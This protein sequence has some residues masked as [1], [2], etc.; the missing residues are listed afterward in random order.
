MRINNN[1]LHSRINRLE[2]LMS[3]TTSDVKKLELSRDIRLLKLML[4]YTEGTNYEVDSINLLFPD[5]MYNLNKELM[6][7]FNRNASNIF[8]S[9]YGYS[10]RVRLPLKLTL[11]RRITD[12]VYDKLLI[13]F[14]KEYDKRLLDIYMLLKREERVEVNP[15][16]YNVSSDSLGLNVH[17][18]SSDE[19]FIFSRF[20]GKIGMSSIIP[21]ELGHSF[22]H[23]GSNNIYTFMKRNGSLFSEAYSIFLEMIFYDYLKNTKYSKSAFKAE[24]NKL[25]SFLAISEYL[26]SIILL[27]E[28]MDFKDGKLYLFGSMPADTYGAKLVLSNMLAMYF[29][30]LYRNNKKQFNI[31]INKFFEMYDYAC[32]EEKLKQ[33]KLDDMVSGTNSVLNSYIKL[34]KK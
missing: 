19:S 23:L 21:H 11:D 10:S 14:F 31:E 20:N 18:V 9:L 26:H 5:I 12:D 25:D 34:Y 8:K 16:K 3:S 22:L 29:V 30:S 1:D 6:V 17:L 4:N 15:K 33:F 2:E 13:D 28:N 32:D 24:Y 27:F 7:F